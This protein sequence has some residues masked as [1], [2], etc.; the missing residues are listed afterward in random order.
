VRLVRTEGAQE[1][2]AL[3]R[4][5][6]QLELAIE[7]LEADQAERLAAASRVVAAAIEA[8]TEAQKCNSSNLT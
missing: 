7:T 2:D 3:A 6:E 5:A 1:L 4:E 8:A